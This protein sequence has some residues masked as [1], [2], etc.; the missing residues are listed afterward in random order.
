MK[1]DLCS[2]I[3]KVRELKGFSQD[4]VA[5]QLGI[6]QRAYSKIE[7]NLTKLDWSRI[8]KLSQLFGMSPIGLIVF[9]NPEFPNNSS[10]TCVGGNWNIAFQEDLKKIIEEKLSE[11]KD[12]MAI[13]K[14][15][16][17][18]KN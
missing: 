9:D 13:L 15:L 5:I 12:E 16:V 8:E 3:R 4:Y 7:N 11:L 1:N 18:A 2:T 6:S 14:E 10:A 17:E